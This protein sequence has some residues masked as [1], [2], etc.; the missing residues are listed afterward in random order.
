MYMLKTFTLPFPCLFFLD[1]LL[2]LS[3]SAYNFGKILNVGG[4]ELSEEDS[5]CLCIYMTLISEWSIFRFV[6]F[7]GVIA[8]LEKTEIYSTLRIMSFY[9]EYIFQLTFCGNIP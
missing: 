2:K 3:S 9:R 7:F 1:A 5:L 4:L 6:G 8:G